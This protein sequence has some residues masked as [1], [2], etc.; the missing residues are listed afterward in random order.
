MKKSFCQSGKKCYPDEHHTDLF[1][2][3][4]KGSNYLWL[5]VIRGK[6]LNTVLH[7]AK[8]RLQRS[9]TFSTNITELVLN[10]IW[11][12]WQNAQRVTLLSFCQTVLLWLSTGRLQL[13]PTML[14]YWLHIFLQ[15]TMGP[16]LSAWLSRPRRMTK[17]N[18]QSAYWV[19]QLRGTTP[20][21]EL[22]DNLT[23]GRRSK[24]SAEPNIQ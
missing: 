13:M 2:V 10:N 11:H 15:T 1:T 18:C 5:G 6:M 12:A 8:E 7:R 9:H 4:P 24:A 16:N 22:S 20:D 14:V 3:Q 17:R 21:V 23:H 19:K